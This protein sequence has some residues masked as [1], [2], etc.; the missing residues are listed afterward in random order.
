MRTHSDET[1]VIGLCNRVLRREALRGHRF[2][3]LVGDKGHRLPVDAYYSDLNLV[4][5]YRERQHTESVSL[6]DNRPTISG[7]SR[8]L[9]RARYDQRRRDVLPKHGLRL[10]ELDY[11]QFP[12]DGRKRLKRTRQDISVVRKVLKS[13][14]AV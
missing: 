11:S 9:Q 8:G 3:F 6:F 14:A 12:H 13:T 4:V 7:M 1:Y 10:V 5:E 2:A